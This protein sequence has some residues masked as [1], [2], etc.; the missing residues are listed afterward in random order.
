MM[1]DETLHVLVV[2]IVC[3]VHS[4]TYLFYMHI[5]LSDLPDGELELLDDEEINP[6]SGLTN[7]SILSGTSSEP[8]D[9]CA[10]VGS[11]ADSRSSSSAS[12]GNQS[13]SST[14]S[15]D[16]SSWEDIFLQSK[17]IASSPSKIVMMEKFLLHL[18]NNPDDSQLQSFFQLLLAGPE[19]SPPRQRLRHVTHMSDVMRLFRWVQVLLN[20]M[21]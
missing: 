16:N 1:K 17:D 2:C 20:L 14:S 10:S 4:L 15:D 12:A 9:P 8:S 5:D 18:R 19:F 6:E 21:I 11:V 7:S 3:V 13:S